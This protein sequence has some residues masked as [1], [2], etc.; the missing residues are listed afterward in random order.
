MKHQSALIA[1]PDMK[2]VTGY[3][4][5]VMEF[6][7]GEKMDEFPGVLDTL[8]A[9]SCTRI[10]EKKGHLTRG[11]A[12]YAL[13]G[14]CTGVSVFLVFPNLIFMTGQRSLVKSTLAC[15]FLSFFGLA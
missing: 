7:I 5:T 11:M 8:S 4:L 12:L 15:L 1:T 9:A 10:T 14:D 3:V 6:S 13:N 2:E